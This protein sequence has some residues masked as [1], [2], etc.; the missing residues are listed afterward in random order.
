[1]GDGGIFSVFGLKILWILFLCMRE[2]RGVRGRGRWGCCRRKKKGLGKREMGCKRRREEEE[3]EERGERRESFV[4]K[5][6][7]IHWVATVLPDTSALILYY[8]SVSS[9]RICPK[10]TFL[11]KLSLDW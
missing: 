8:K 4:F 11:A 3:E 5:I 9:N 7:I 6:I 2:R 10:G 1:V